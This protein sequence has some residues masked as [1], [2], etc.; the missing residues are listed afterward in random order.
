MSKKDKFSSLLS[1]KSDDHKPKAAHDELLNDGLFNDSDI[2]DENKNTSE[3]ASENTSA[4]ELDD[5]ASRIVNISKKNKPKKF[6]DTHSKA[7]YWIRNDVL[8]A[9]NKIAGNQRGM[10]TEIVNQALI[11]YF[12]K[13]EK[14]MKKD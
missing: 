2:K 9:F 11:D 7:T 4:N 12:I 13:L 1:K 6:E 14:E 8:K 10:K 5:I 3:D